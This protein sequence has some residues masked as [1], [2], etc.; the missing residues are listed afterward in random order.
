MWGVEDARAMLAM[1]PLAERLG[2]DS[3]WVMDHLLHTGFVT[4]RLGTR[5]YWHPLAVL[6]HLSATTSRVQLGTGVLVAWS[7][8]AVLI[9]VPAPPLVA[10]PPSATKESRAN[11]VA[12]TRPRRPARRPGRSSWRSI[13][14]AP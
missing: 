8:P 2:F 4:E 6:S 12:A 1:G 11:V 9:A 7:I 13:R 3:V 10:Q 5:P 14:I